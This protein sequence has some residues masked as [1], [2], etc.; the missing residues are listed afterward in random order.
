MNG[1]NIFASTETG[2]VTVFLDK[3]DDVSEILTLVQY[4]HRKFDEKNAAT[5]LKRFAQL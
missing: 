4:H 5:A 1:P 3:C 2:A